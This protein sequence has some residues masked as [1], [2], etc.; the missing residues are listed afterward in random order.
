[1]FVQLRVDPRQNVDFAEMRTNLQDSRVKLRR[2][3][4]VPPSSGIPKLNFPCAVPQFRASLTTR[5]CRWFV[6]RGTNEDQPTA[7]RRRGLNMQ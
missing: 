5:G 6:V 3:K 7:G 2:N 1:M 4:F